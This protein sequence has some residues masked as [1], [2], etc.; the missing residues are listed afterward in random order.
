MA[1]GG[2]GEFRNVAFGIS[3]FAIIYP[4]DNLRVNFVRRTLDSMVDEPQW[5]CHSSVVRLAI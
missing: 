3:P 2:A 1:P 4:W 5:S